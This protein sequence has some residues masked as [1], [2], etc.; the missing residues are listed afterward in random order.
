MK[1]PDYMKDPE[2][3]LWALIVGALIAVVQTDP[4]FWGSLHWIL[5]V[6]AAL[7]ITGVIGYLLGVEVGRKKERYSR[8]QREQDIERNAWINRRK[9]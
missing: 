7:L 3:Y 9:R 6:A 1:I 8:Y 5:F 2:R 4:W